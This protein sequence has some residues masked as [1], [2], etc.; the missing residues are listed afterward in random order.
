MFYRIKVD[1]Y[2][3]H[4]VDADFYQKQQHS[5]NF[6]LRIS[7]LYVK[8]IFSNPQQFLRCGTLSM[9]VSCGRRYRAECLQE[10]DSRTT[11][12]LSPWRITYP[13]WRSFVN[14]AL[15][16]ISAMDKERYINVSGRPVPR[17]R[18][19]CPDRETRIRTAKVFID[20]YRRIAV[21][22]FLCCLETELSTRLG[23]GPYVRKVAATKPTRNRKVLEYPNRAVVPRVTVKDS[24]IIFIEAVLF[25]PARILATYWSSIESACVPLGGRGQ[26]LGWSQ[27]RKGRMH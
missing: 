11:R 14:P 12:Q 10:W 22:R 23:F 25:F 7:W 26:L 17:S 19:L 21:G 1:V 3:L 18:P 4:A 5:F 13:R 24:G 27:N 6:S 2:M 9:M 16:T 20:E 15:T 8:K